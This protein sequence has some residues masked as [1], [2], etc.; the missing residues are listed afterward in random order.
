MSESAADRL[1]VIEAC[2]RMAWHADQRDWAALRDVFA[3]EV[4]LD[5]TSLQGG[6]PA[7]VSRDELVASWAGL[8]GKLQATQHL[9]TNHLVAVSGNEASCTAAFQA[10]HLLPN[11]HGDPIWTLGGSYRFQ[12]VRDGAT[13]R[14]SALTMT[15]TW[16]SGNQQIM[17]LAAGGAS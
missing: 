17:S 11:A 3:N 12:L 15:A 5:Y 13:W 8:L 4:R 6:E 16:A 14:I 7:T 2:T 1:D 9:L 10:T